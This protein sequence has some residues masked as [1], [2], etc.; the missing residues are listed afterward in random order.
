MASLVENAQLRK[1]GRAAHAVQDHALE[2][3]CHGCASFLLV[4]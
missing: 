3:R 4:G 1:L 2:T